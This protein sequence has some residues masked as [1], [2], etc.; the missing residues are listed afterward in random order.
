ML[1]IGRLPVDF[2]GW[3][4]VLLW[5]SLAS[6]FLLLIVARRVF[7]DLVDKDEGT[8]AMIAAAEA[9][10]RAGRALEDRYRVV[11]WPVAAVALLLLVAVPAP[12]LGVRVGR[13][14]AV[15]LGAG[16]T[17]LVGVAA[18]GV[19]LRGDCRVTSAARRTLRESFTVAIRAGG[20]V[21]LVAAGL[22]VL[23]DTVV[24]LVFRQ[25]APFVLVGY[26]AGAAIVALAFRTG[27]GVVAEAAAAGLRLQEG[28]TALPNVTEGGQGYHHP[29]VVVAMASE[30][31]RGAAGTATELFVVTDLVFLAALALASPAVSAAGGSG[32]V[33]LLVAL[34][35]LC[36][37]LGAA[38]S[39]VGM[40]VATPGGKVDPRT[41]D[42]VRGFLLAV[43]LTAVVTPAVAVLLTGDLRPA[44]ALEVGLVLAGAVTVLYGVGRGDRRRDPSF[45]PLVGSPAA[46]GWTPPD[47]AVS[48]AASSIFFLL[49][50]ASG[51]VSAAV[52]GTGELSVALYA[53]ALTGVGLLSVVAAAAALGT[54]APVAAGGAGLGTM[55]GPLSSRAL[56]A[57][58][59]LTGEAHSSARVVEAYV[60]G[61]AG[62]G[63][64]ALL[65]PASAV[66]ELSSAPG[67]LGLGAPRLLV[68]LLLG[69]VL[70]LLAGS[71][72]TGTQA[73]A[74]AE[75][76][77]EVRIQLRDHGGILT[78]VERPDLGRLADATAGRSL[79]ELTA[80]GVL[81]VLA[82][83]ILGYVLGPG[84]L[85]AAVAGAL[86]VTPLAVLVV[87][88]DPLLAGTHCPPLTPVLILMAVSAMIV[89]PSV[90]AAAGHPAVE[91]GTAA[92]AAGLLGGFLLWWRGRRVDAP[93][94]SDQRPGR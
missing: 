63:V 41:W 78:G 91:T 11:V 10:R 22:G 27:G 58:T 45:L 84:A 9:V 17:S 19:S 26:A 56:T 89:E 68:G 40:V 24:I 72:I 66:G 83:V 73:R 16:L 80:P 42:L 4:R 57:L 61:A 37:V 47:T 49:I 36:R 67:D 32:D 70:P 2:S 23:G 34:P 12:G 13:S 30:V 18:I 31:V 21:G 48:G 6:A 90:R 35:L 85:A 55:N 71:L 38:A 52:I 1:E 92:L 69:A 43:G 60:G 65:A 14:L 51:V 15:V 75:L 81:A 7:G 39:W 79:V 82:P 76:V 74:A 94:L 88:R 25:Q 8:D 86:V 93:W 28:A 64:V 62:L 59:R 33:G 77:Q 87:P 44:L 29:G 46:E 54:F 20:V 5:L 50:V 53:V 3:P